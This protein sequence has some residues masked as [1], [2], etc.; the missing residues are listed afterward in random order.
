[1]TQDVSGVKAHWESMGGAGEPVLLLHGW[2]PAS[3]SLRTH[4]S[5]LAYSLHHR[6][7]LYALDFPGHGESG[8]PGA[9]WGV[10]EYAEWTLKVMDA[11]ALARV[12]VIAHSFGG[13]VALWLAANHPERVNRLVLTGCAGMRPRRTLS[14]RA[15]TLLFKIGRGG[16]GAASLV[17]RLRPWSQEQLASLRTEFSSA[18]YLATPEALRASFSKIVRQD[19]SPILPQIRQPVLLVWG[20]KDTATPLWMGRQMN[21][22]HADSRL[23]VYAADD[24]FAY[25]NQLARFATAAEVFLSGGDKP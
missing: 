7:Q 20:E 8:M 10:P 2:G 9:D 21:E 16:L 18:D 5:P 15:R 17:P 19:L 22:N 3:V 23:L 14:S 4:L 6:F 25:L 1:M 24:H 11:L 12:S 13:R